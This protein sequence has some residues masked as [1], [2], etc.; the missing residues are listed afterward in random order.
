MKKLQIQSVLTTGFSAVTVMAIAF[1]A[2][3]ANITYDFTVTPD[4]GPLLGESYSGSF[5]FDDSALIGFD[6]EFITVDSLSFS[7]LGVDYT[8]ADGALGEPEVAFFDGSFLGLEF[9][10]DG[11][12][13]VPGFFDLSEAFFTYD[14]ASG[15]G[16]GDIIYTQI[17]DQKSVPE[18]AS[19]LALLAIGAA[20]ATSALRRQSA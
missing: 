18:P 10:E 8:E 9:S 3:A 14:L 13:F 19:V 20:G 4:V 2:S 1:P 11:F 16:A 6:A 5:T 12:S 17:P 15:S 7:F